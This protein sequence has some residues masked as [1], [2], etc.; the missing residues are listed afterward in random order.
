ML[1]LII[2][3]NAFKCNECMIVVSTYL[4]FGIEF[5]C[6]TIIYQIYKLNIYILSKWNENVKIHF[7]A[8]FFYKEL[9]QHIFTTC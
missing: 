4:D 5:C 2:D 7:L 9:S 8:L 1:I 6:E 3:W